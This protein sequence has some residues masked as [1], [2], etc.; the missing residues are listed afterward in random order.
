MNIYGEL[1]TKD[2]TALVGGL[3]EGGRVLSVGAFQKDRRWP[4]QALDRA[5]FQIAID[6]DATQAAGLAAGTEIPLTFL[7]ARSIPDYIGDNPQGSQRESRDLGLR[8]PHRRRAGG[9]G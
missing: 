9:R 8:L 6:L 5:L 3:K 7:R 1:A 2:V 4:S